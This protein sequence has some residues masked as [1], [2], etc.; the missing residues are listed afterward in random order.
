LLSRGQIVPRLIG[1]GSAAA[2]IAGLEQLDLD[3]FAPFRLVAIDAGSE[4]LLLASWDR[5][6]LTLSR[7]AK[8]TCLVS[9]GLGDSKVQGRLEVFEEMVVRRALT[10]HA[11][12]R[13]HLHTWPDHPE[14][15]VLM[16][17]PDARTVSITTVEVSTGENRALGV[18]MTHQPVLE[19]HPGDN[20][21]KARPMALLGHGC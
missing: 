3:C 9:S 6:E 16:S 1:T 18:R 11:Q 7:R 8:P 19:G 13:F 21:L 14:L 20:A 12:D 10:P 2:A 4:T 5:T 17:R 15:S